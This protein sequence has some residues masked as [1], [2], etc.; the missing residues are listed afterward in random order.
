M[1]FAKSV[2]ALTVAGLLWIADTVIPDIPGIPTWISTL[3]VPVCFLIAVIYALVYTHK[4]YLKAIEREL[5]DKDAIINMLDGFHKRDI[6]SRERLTVTIQK[7]IETNEALL[8][9]GDKIAHLVS[10]CPY[11]EA[12]RRLANEQQK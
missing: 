10:G 7:L 1:Q 5:K 4:S 6:E 11:A 9:S 3:G 2:M 8:S 12:A